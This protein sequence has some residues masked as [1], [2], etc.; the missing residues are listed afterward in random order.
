MESSDG[1]RGMAARP[2]WLYTPNVELRALSS[3]TFR[4]MGSWEEI[5]AQIRQEQE[6][7]ALRVALYPCSPLQVL[8]ERRPDSGTATHP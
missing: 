8:R 6:E 1:G 4:I 3:G 2:I 7:R 5:V